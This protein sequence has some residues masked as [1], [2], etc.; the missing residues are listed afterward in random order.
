MATGHKSAAANTTAALQS[1]HSGCSLPSF[2]SHACFHEVFPGSMQ[3]RAS[4]VTTS[5]ASENLLPKIASAYLPP[6][7]SQGGNFMDNHDFSSQNSSANSAFH[8]DSGFLHASQPCH[9]GSSPVA[10]FP[11]SLSFPLGSSFSE[12]GAPILHPDRF[13]GTTVVLHGLLPGAMLDPL[14]DVD[15]IGS[16]GFLQGGPA[17]QMGSDLLSPASSPGDGTTSGFVSGLL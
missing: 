6:V 4:L 2:P 15:P 1:S 12:N 11:S 13:L 3:E 9:V 10:A 14:G 17:F 16:L 8:L 5:T 7:S